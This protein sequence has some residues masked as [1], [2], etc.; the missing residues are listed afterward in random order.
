MEKEILEPL[1]DLTLVEKARVESVR[2][3]ALLQMGVQP[4]PLVGLGLLHLRRLLGPA[5][6]LVTPLGQSEIQQLYQDYK[7]KFGD[8]PSPEADPTSDQL[9]SLTKVVTA[10]SVPYAD[11]SLFAVRPPRLVVAPKDPRLTTHG[12]RPGKCAARPS[13]ASSP[14]SAI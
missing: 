4:T 3:V 12:S 11:F 10:G 5:R 14:S 7:T 9:A 8:Y 1:V 13:G 6:A 2:R